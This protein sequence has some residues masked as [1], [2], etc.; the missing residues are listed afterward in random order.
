MKVRYGLLS[1][2]W[3]YSF[4]LPRP[5]NAICAS[6]AHQNLCVLDAHSHL[7]PWG[8]AGFFSTGSVSGFDLRDIP[9]CPRFLKGII[10]DYNDHVLW[11]LNSQATWK[12]CLK[13]SQNENTLAKQKIRSHPARR[14]DIA[15]NM[16]SRVS[17]YVQRCCKN[18]IIYLSIIINYYLLSLRLDSSFWHFGVHY[19]CTFW[20]PHFLVKSWHTHDTWYIKWY[21]PST[22]HHVPLPAGLQSSTLLDVPRKK[23]QKKQLASKCLATT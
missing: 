23:K 3:Q 6:Q 21:H 22:W 11:Y 15:L 12:I 18:M 10:N 7:S 4:S 8:M 5:G 13:S 20:V 17:G 1:L 19:W 2:L 14:S 9:R 16:G